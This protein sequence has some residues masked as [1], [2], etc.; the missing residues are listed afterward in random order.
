MLVGPL[1]AQHPQVA[2]GG[3]SLQ[4]WRVPVNTLVKQPR[5]DDNVW[6][7]SMEVGRG[8]NNPSQ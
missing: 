5:T 4:L 6:C 8:A 1:S 3:N 7:S 2:D